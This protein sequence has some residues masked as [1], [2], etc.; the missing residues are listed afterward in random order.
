MHAICSS[1]SIAVFQ[2]VL[3]LGDDGRRRAT[4]GILT[5]GPQAD[6]LSKGTDAAKQKT[7]QFMEIVLLMNKR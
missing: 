4:D 2:L 6:N 7:L 1:N 5:C 3:T